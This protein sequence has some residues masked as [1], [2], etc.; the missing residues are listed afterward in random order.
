MGGTLNGTDTWSTATAA[1][2]S[3]GTP[4]PADMNGIANAAS[5]LFATEFW[6]SPSNGWKHE[7]STTTAWSTCKT[8][9][10]PAGST[11]STVSGVKALTADFGTLVTGI[12]P[13]CALVFSLLTGFPGRKMR[14]R[15]YLPSTN[16]ITSAG[17]AITTAVTNA[18]TLW[19]NYLSAINDM[20]TG[21]LSFNVCVGT[22]DCPAITSVKVDDVI[23]TQRR[24]RD[25]QTSG[26]TVT[27]PLP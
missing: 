12:P 3:G 15:N 21:P 11:V 10:Y 8:Y 24:R 7:V 9:F 17:H 26:F 1:V 19:A 18:S 14:G 22:G 13:Q 27:T 5:V 25:K 20:T 2:V 16:R 23:D 6:T 4:S